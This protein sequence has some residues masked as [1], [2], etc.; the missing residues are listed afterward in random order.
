[1]HDLK[2]KGDDVMK[3]LNLKPGPDVGKILKKLFKEVEDKKVP[4]EKE[5]LLERVKKTKT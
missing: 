2:I 4:N 3:E 5:A 1:M